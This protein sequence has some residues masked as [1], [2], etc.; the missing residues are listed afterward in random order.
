MEERDVLDNTIHT[1]TG[2]KVAWSRCMFEKKKEE[3]GEGE[4]CVGPRGRL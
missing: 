1:P 4:K 3:E 2:L